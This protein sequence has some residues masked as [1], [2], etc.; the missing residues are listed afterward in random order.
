MVLEILLALLGGAAV[1]A[2]LVWALA[3]G[4][5]RT[6]ETEMRVASERLTAELASEKQRA[7]VL[8]AERSAYA[9]RDAAQGRQL[10]Q[11]ESDRAG[12]ESSVRHLTDAAAQQ[13]IALEAAATSHS[14]LR[15]QNA[16]LGAQV[17]R[18]RT[19][20][21]AEQKNAKEKLETLTAAKQDMANQF[22]ALANKILDEKSKKFTEQNQANLG[23]LIAPIKEKFSE[24]QQKVESL[25]KDGIAGRSE[26][27]TEIAQLRTLNE[28]LSQE[29]NNLAGALKG[30]SKTQGDWGEYVLE[31][32][33]EASG[34]RK[35]HEYR[36][37]KSYAQS[38]DADRANARPDLILDLPG[39]RNL[40]LDAKVSLNQYSTYCNTEDGQEREV[41][42]KQHLS[43]V[44]KHIRDLSDRNY[45]KLY[46]INTPDFVVMFVPIEPAFML[47]ISH[48]GNLWQEAWDKNILLVSP[49]TLLFVLRTVSHLWR[50]ELQAKSIQDIVKK[51]GALYDK[52]AGV[53]EDLTQVG[54]R[55]GKAQE[56]YESAYKKLALGQNNAL[57]QAEAFKKLGVKPTKS[58]IKALPQKIAEVVDLDAV[59]VQE[60]LLELAAAEENDSAKS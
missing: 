8:Q 18:L 53:L 2:A 42:L 24:F 13:K 45:Q 43:S 19:A 44:R 4:R 30:S 46:D 3:A 59:P 31:S 11:L 10:T 34:L 16:E 9:E 39:K 28:R 40:I 54:D 47:A 60:E 7:T 49:S 20:F 36:V 35:G 26:L 21:E 52:L 17:A 51:G 25:E 33:L 58:I 22:E 29:A 23:N 41:A 6:H 32:I 57:Q 14:E 55:L 38:E 1:G 27:K 37:Q 50:Q 48:D 56:A 5:S 12:L 15:T